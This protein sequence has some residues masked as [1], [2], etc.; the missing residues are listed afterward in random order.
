[1]ATPGTRS[2]AGQQKFVY[3]I[4]EALPENLIRGSNRNFVNLDEPREAHALGEKLGGEGELDCD[5]F[6]FTANQ[7]EQFEWM[8]RGLVKSR[9]GTTVKCGNAAAAL[10]HQGGRS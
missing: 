8:I 6:L 4:C 5:L 2:A 1:M 9:G 10:L 7:V 3:L